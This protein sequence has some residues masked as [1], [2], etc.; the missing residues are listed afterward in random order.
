M[1]LLGCMLALLLPPLTES[2]TITL[3][4]TDNITIHIKRGINAPSPPCYICTPTCKESS[5]EISRGKR[6]DY[7]FSCKTP[8]MYFIMEIIRTINCS[9]GGCPLNVTL[10]PSDLGG[11]NRTFIWNIVTSKN[12]G[13]I[14]GFSTPWLRQIHPSSQCSDLVSFNISTYVR[15][16]SY[17]IG[18]FCRNGT[19]TRIKVQERGVIALSLP[20][21]A[22]IKGL[23]ISITN[24]SSIRRLSIV[25]S[26]FQQQSL[27]NLLSANYPGPFPP[28]EQMTWKF[29]FPENYA[30]SVQFLNYTLPTCVKKE[31]NVLYYLPKSTLLKLADKQP[32]NILSSF[33]LSLQNCEVDKP[34][35]GYPGL[36]LNFSITV[37]KSEQNT[38]YP[39]DLLNEKGLVVRIRK[40][41]FGRQF[42]PVC[43]ICKGSTDCNSDLVL[44]GGKYYRISFLCDNLNSLVVT[45][46]KEIECWN[47]TACNIRNMSLTIPQSFIGFPVQLESYTWK[48][49]APEYISTEIVS[50]S[51]YLQQHVS[52]KPCNATT[53]GFTYDILSSTN[54]SEF[55]LGT[56]CPNGSIEK[57]QMRD[58]VT[59]ILN[60]P[61]NGDLNKLPTHDL[62]VSFVSFIKEECI[63]TVSP[64]TE[65]TIHLQT[66]HWDNGL[67]D[68]VSVSWSIN[69]PK[70]RSGRLKFGQDKMDISCEMGRA[71]VNIREQQD[72]GPGIVR[73]EDQQLPSVLDMYSA[74][75]VNISNCK[76]WTG[77]RKLKL[78]VSITFNQISPVLKIILIAA[79]AALGVVLAVIATVCCIKKK[80]KQ[81]ETPVGIYN[82]KVNTEAP[83][84][85]AFFKKGRKTNESHIYAVIDDTMVYGHLLPETEGT[86]PEVDVYQPFEGPMGDAPPVPPITFPNG[87][88]KEDVKDG[89]DII[90]EEPLAL[91]MKDNEIYIFS[92]SISRHPVENEDTSIPYMD[93]SRS[94]TTSV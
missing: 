30:A 89:S 21:N 38:I 34:M 8:E 71:Y 41:S 74:F 44:E 9:T 61:R 47:L 76:P 11:L 52:D 60:I 15:D 1:L 57:I 7:S 69:L 4:S 24:R 51:T 27:V 26:I 23:G 80:K 29:I 20:W 50:K 42:T 67:P 94:G 54:K 13:L 16:S 14:L 10:Q 12:S 81:I 45:A 25:E 85:Q 66:P 28:N 56:F 78:Q 36:S 64:K 93:D 55:K 72:D 49:I 79:S 58:N 86:H 5:L 70:K 31:E 40:R 90:M 83:R 2:V 22:N 87:N 53:V 65:D 33:N 37:Q 17:N 43:V 35:S 46:E 63:F 77:T 39:L 73:R 91:S 92:Q 19:I 84:R 48:L 6:V 68:Y 32:A 59:I 75:W 62:Q 88:A 3:P 18:T 82:S